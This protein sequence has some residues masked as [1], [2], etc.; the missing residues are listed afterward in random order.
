MIFEIIA[1]MIQLQ[2]TKVKN[3]TKAVR[4]IPGDCCYNHIIGLLL[5]D[6]K[7]IGPRINLAEELIDMPH[8]LFMNKV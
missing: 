5:K 1:A 2:I 3:K 7:Q 6:D 4:S 8:D